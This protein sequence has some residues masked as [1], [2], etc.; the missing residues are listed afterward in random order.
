MIDVLGKSY[1]IEHCI[2]EIKQRRED[3]RYREYMA[4]TSRA[5]SMN[6]AVLSRGSYTTIGYRE[7]VKGER[8]EQEHK[9]A[10]RK[11]GDAVKSIRDKF[12][13]KGE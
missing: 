13:E 3:D 10:E 4:E 6:L 12:K 11:A 5:I 1:I 7:Y 9:E 2:S 8:A